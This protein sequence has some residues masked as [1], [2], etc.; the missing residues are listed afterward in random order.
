[1]N[2]QNLESNNIIFNQSNELNLSDSNL[3]ETNI[4]ETNLSKKILEDVKGCS[5]SLSTE[6]S[7][8]RPT[9]TLVQKKKLADR[10]EN[11]KTKKHFKQIFKII[12]ESSDNSYTKD[13]SGVYINFNSLSNN[14]IK[15]IEDYLNIYVPKIDTIPLQSK[16]TPYFS[17][18]YNPKDSGIKLSNH[19]KNFLKHV[20]HSTLFEDT[21]NPLRGHSAEGTINPFRGRE[22]NTSSNI[23]EGNDSDN[24]NNFIESESSLKSSDQN[25]TKILIKPFTF[26]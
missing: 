20:G 8:N 18:E 7:S 6:Q 9:Y 24:K 22:Y 21:I 14:T 13:S 10:I 15:L 5:A 3:S 1:M 23:F 11:L 17:D 19:E 4:S 2:N 25:K 26:E 12:Y 16:Y